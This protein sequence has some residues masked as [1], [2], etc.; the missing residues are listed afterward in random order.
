M[1]GGYSH[2]T[3]G[4]PQALAAEIRKLQTDLA[5]LRRGLA[6]LGIQIDTV[7]NELVIG[8]GRSLIV[9]GSE[10][11][12]GTLTVTGNTLIEGNLSVPN[13]SITNAFLQNPTSP[14]VASAVINSTNLT[15]AGANLA[16][17]TI[18]VPSGF[19]QAQVLCIATVGN[20]RTLG[21]G[22]A[23]FYAQAWIGSTISAVYGE[24]CAD[25]SSDLITVAWAAD[26][27]GVSGTIQ[28]GAWGA[29]DTTTGWTSGTANAH[30]VV[31]VT[32]LR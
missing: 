29:V 17:C 27:T 19:S 4:T 16:T 21:A 25:G 13:G 15:V 28:A 22:G 24:T 2:Q 32:F 20:T 9:N 10:T 23:P 31:Q 18:S 1:G 11:V 26:L 6:N 3:K 30:S 5:A 7:D 8:A 12:G 14:A